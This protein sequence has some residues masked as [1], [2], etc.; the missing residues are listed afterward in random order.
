MLSIIASTTGPVCLYTLSE[1]NNK[2]KTPDIDNAI[3][4]NQP[5]RN[6]RG[7]RV[8]LITIVCQQLKPR[9][10]LKHIVAY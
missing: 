4:T 5:G 10:M 2:K 1:P 8:V 3:R 6:S 9:A 7:N